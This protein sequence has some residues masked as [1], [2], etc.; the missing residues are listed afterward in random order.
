MNIQL[1]MRYPGLF[2]D[3]MSKINLESK[4]L[5]VQV[6]GD[7][8]YIFIPSENETKIVP[9]KNIVCLEGNFNLIKE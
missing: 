3:S 2:G 5:N 7:I 1:A 6:K 8:T 4:I 9:N